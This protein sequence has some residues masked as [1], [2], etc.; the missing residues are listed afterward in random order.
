MTSVGRL[1]DGKYLL[2]RPLGQGGMG[3]VWVAEHIELRSQVAVKFIHAPIAAAEHARRRFSREARAAAALRGPNV[4]QVF[5]YGI[6]QR[7]PY[8]V[9]ELLKGETLR[10]RLAA[11]RQLSV[12]HVRVL[13]LQVANAL[14]R[15]HEQ[16]IVHRDL[17]PENIFLAKDDEPFT[18]KLLDFGLAKIVGKQAT[19]AGELT[20]PG[21]PIGTLQYMSPEQLKGGNVDERT[22]VWAFGVVVFE[23]LTGV[24]PFKASARHRLLKAMENIRRP[25]ESAQLPGEFDAWFARATQFAKS[26]RERDVRKLAKELAALTRGFEGRCEVYATPQEQLLRIAAYPSTKDSSGQ[27]AV[28]RQASASLPAAINGR[29]DLE[30]IAL[31]AKLSRNTGVLWTRHKPDAGQW[32]RL[33]LHFQDQESGHNTLAKVLRINEE[34]SARPSMWAYE[35]TVR[36]AQPLEQALVPRSRTSR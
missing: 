10:A 31:I 23:C 1:V 22:D 8:I 11:E 7:D 6:D 19:M 27:A 4:V 15:A 3:A 18:V 35:L 26:G 24:L 30:H 29:R 2:Q 34:P 14:R 20:L 5:D 9:M 17:K 21:N 28:S 25:S 12:E 33:T 32:I 13:A 36:F 16:G